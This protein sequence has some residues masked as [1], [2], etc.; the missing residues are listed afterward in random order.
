MIEKELEKEDV[1]EK[2]E[3]RE[4]IACVMEALL[5][6][7]GAEAGLSPG[8]YAKS[9]GATAAG[10]IGRGVFYLYLNSKEGNLNLQGYARQPRRPELGVDTLSL[11]LTAT[12][13]C[14]LE[15]LSDG[16]SNKAI[17]DELFVSVNTI[18]THVR[19]IFQ[20][21]NVNCRSAAVRRALDLG[22]AG[23]SK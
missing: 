23:C 17:A 8:A 2:D 11:R 12:E 6:P 15:K 9:G 21:L 5:M 22:I 4:P 10:S 18:K 19:S 20:K 13:T 1:I 14:V 3:A 16:K 7:V